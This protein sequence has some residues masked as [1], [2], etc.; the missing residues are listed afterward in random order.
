MLGSIG[1]ESLV[2]AVKSMR[3]PELAI[4]FLVGLCVSY[5]GSSSQTE[6]ERYG[7]V[8][9]VPGTPY[10]SIYL[11][12][13]ADNEQ[14]VLDTIAEF[15]KTN[16]I[17]KCFDFPG[18]YTGPPLAAYTG[19][20]IAV[21][22]RSHATGFV[23]TNR[24]RGLNFGTSFD[25]RHWPAGGSV[26]TNGVQVFQTPFTAIV[27]VSPFGTNYSL[28]KFVQVSDGLASA[29]RLAFTNRSVYMFTSATN[30]P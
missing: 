30:K 28:Q 4:V 8:H 29:L 27:S 13:E 21:F 24:A 22:I 9:V 10:C 12:L 5:G 14:A 25:F 23:S 6:W 16:A 19:D 20:H 26:E 17:R 3:K 11:G 1:T 2:E 18:G 15:A 7:S